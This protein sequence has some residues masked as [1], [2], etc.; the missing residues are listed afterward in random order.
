M[1]EKKRV[2]PHNFVCFNFVEDCIQMGAILLSIILPI[3]KPPLS[4]THPLG[5]VIAIVS[6][7]K[8]Q[9]L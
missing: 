7:G 8:V 1:D 5:I 2:Y 4:K 3:R 9:G 6:L